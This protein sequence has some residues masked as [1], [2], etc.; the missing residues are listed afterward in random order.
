MAGVLSTRSQGGNT[1][2]RTRLVVA[3]RRARLPLLIL[4]DGSAWFVALTLA[5]MLRFETWTVS[6]ALT[7]S[8]AGSTVPLFGVLLLGAIAALVHCALGWL[9]R[10]HQGR[11]ATGGF[12][13]MFVLGSVVLA[14]G[15]TIGVIDMF[16]E[17]QLLPRTS[18]LMATVIVFVFCAWP[19][20]LWRIAVAQSR[21]VGL[22]GAGTP[23]IVAGAGEAGRD[24]VS[25]M[26]RDPRR[27]WEPVAYL[28]DDRHKKH[29]RHRG[30][31]VRGTMA[32]LPRVA[33][34]T[35][36]TTVIIAMPS[37]D[38]DVTSRVY[39]LARE[40]GLDVKVLPNVHELLD[41]NVS[42]ADVRDIS[43]ADLLGRHQVETDL[44][45]IAHHLA[46]RR[47]LVTG[48]GGSIGSELCRQ[49][50]RFDP[51]RLVMLDRD[52]S[53]LH[54]L[55]LALE[56]RADLESRD[57]VL[58]DIRDAHRMLEVF[59]THRPE[60]VF[61]AAALKHVNMLEQHPAE[62]VKTNVVGTANVLAAAR[63]SGVSRFVNISTDKA[64]DPENALGWSKRLAEG[65][66]AQYGASADGTYLSVRFGNVLGTRGSV[67]TTFAAQ[68][69]AGGPVTVT[70]EDVTRFFMTVDEAVQ[71][72][73]QAAVI[74]RD[75]EALVLDMGEPVRILDVAR[76][77]IEQ[78]GENVDLL[79]TGLKPGEKLHEVLFAASEE[80]ERPVHPLV[81]HVRVPH[82]RVPSDAIE[83]TG[84]AQAT[85][86][87]LRE[88]CDKMASNH[89]RE[90]TT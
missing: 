12:E 24:L 27:T 39:D 23:V 29:F 28:D 66:T 85:M 81:S 34:S 61:H 71:L 75:G 26:Q 33:D 87:A 64:A 40:V 46:G 17:P 9:L 31:P 62:A 36:A 38:S 19:R 90:A 80:D 51:E 45:A 15:I 78:S 79:V 13:E 52:E 49:I 67:L 68:I 59:E 89:L 74:G 88:A 69:K 76:Q 8:D 72:V 14:S 70:H 57:V 50:R 37:V 84:E 11:H 82:T 10:L 48:A 60:V 2:V 77:M 83:V 54:A 16:N 55:L 18:V 21:P 43:P 5:V 56:G 47:V 41:G 3:L 35:G 32:D 22:G 4:L 6:P 1:F 65:L 63:E 53:A 25:T 7:L 44:D 30:V 58:A 20:A 73:I 86:N 42:L